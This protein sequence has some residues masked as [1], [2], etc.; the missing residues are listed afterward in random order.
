MFLCYLV[1]LLWLST[2]VAFILFESNRYFSKAGSMY[3]EM[4]LIADMSY[5]MAQIDLNTNKIWCVLTY[6]YL[7]RNYSQ[8]TPSIL[9]SANIL[10]ESYNKVVIATSKYDY[11]LVYN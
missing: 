8:F 10:Y 6:H 9:Q 11:P 1:I 4:Q 7:T 5:Q 2:Y 3:E